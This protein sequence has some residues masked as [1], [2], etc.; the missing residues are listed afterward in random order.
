MFRQKFDFLIYYHDISLI[1]ACSIISI[2]PFNGLHSQLSF[3]VLCFKIDQVVMKLS[4]K[5]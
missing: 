5:T 4:T 2:I 3:D 1:L